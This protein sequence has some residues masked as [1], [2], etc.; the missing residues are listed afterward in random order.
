MAAG[1]GRGGCVPPPLRPSA[2][3]L[4][5][6]SRPARLTRPLHHCAAMIL[7]KRC[8]PA[9]VRTNDYTLPYVVLIQG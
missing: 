6:T 4:T 7:K 1:A 3:R 5:A 9:L 8:Q 2:R